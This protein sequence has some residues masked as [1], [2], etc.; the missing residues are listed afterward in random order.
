MLRCR[1]NFGVLFLC[2]LWYAISTTSNILNKV[3]LQNFPFP[4]TLTTAS[5]VTTSIYSIP[6]SRRTASAEQA[7]RSLNHKQFF[8]MVVPLAFGKLIAVS[9]SFVSL[10]KVPV[11]YAHTVK[12]TMPI[13]S[14]VCARFIIGE[15]QTKLIYMSL[16]PILLGVMIATVSEMSFS[17]VGL[18]SA[19][20]STFTYALMNAYVKKVIKDTGL[21]HVRLL[22]LIAQTSC[23]LLLP[24]WLIIDVSRYGIVEVGFSKLTVCGLV[25]ASGFLN[26]AQNVCTFSLINQLSVLSYAIA[27]VTKRIIVISSSLITLKNPVTPVNVGGMLLAVVGVF[28]YTQANQLMK[29][30]LSKLPYNIYNVNAN[31]SLAAID[32]WP[33]DTNLHLQNGNNN[34]LERGFKCANILRNGDISGKGNVHLNLGMVASY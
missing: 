5:I 18:C 13:F 11:S 28:G 24:V 31:K 2:L 1:V 12:A 30:K 22:G 26:F 16:I 10:Y 25:S 17:A 33:S 27:N 3:I 34:D 19:L 15:K 14:V 29:S 23:I 4:L 7:S 8:F 21:H 6:V 32:M 20:C 9:S